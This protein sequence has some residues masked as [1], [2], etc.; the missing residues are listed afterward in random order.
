MNADSLEHTLEALELWLN[1]ACPRE[2]EGWI[3]LIA[4]G[5]DQ[6]KQLAKDGLALPQLR[7]HWD[8]VREK[9]EQYRRDEKELLRARYIFHNYKLRGLTITRLERI[10]CNLR[11]ANREQHRYIKLLQEQA[12][13]STK[14]QS[15]GEAK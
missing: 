15:G 4:P 10:V 12:I 7:D 13:N 11:K 8:N 5:W 2:S 14:G 1:K 3:R 6:V 9:S